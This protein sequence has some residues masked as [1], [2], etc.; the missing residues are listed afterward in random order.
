MAAATIVQPR[1]ELARRAGG[2]FE[3]TLLWNAADDST[4]I[5]I[6]HPATEET[7]HFPVPGKNALD[8]FHHPFA[9]LGRIAA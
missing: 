8:A 7:F 1:R 5:E 3:V 2:G 4:S 9:H 6:R